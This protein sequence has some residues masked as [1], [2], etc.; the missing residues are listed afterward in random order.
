MREIGSLDDHDQAVRLGDYLLAQ[1]IRNRVETA[2]GRT[3]IWVIDEDRIDQAMQELDRFRAEPNHDRYA[4]A[5]SAARAIRRDQQAKEKRYRKNVVNVRNRWHGQSWRHR[6]VTTLLLAA[7]IV[8][9]LATWFGTNRAE[10]LMPWLTIVPYQFVLTHDGVD[11]RL[12]VALPRTPLEA[13][14]D[15][16]VWRIVTPIFIHFDVFHLL[17]NM[18]WLVVLGTQIELFRGP[19]RMA[20]FTLL[21]AAASNLGQFAWSLHNSDMPS[22]FIGGMSGVDYALFGYVWMQRMFNPRSRFMLS[23]MTILVMI[24]WLFLCMTPLSFVA[25]VAN[26]AHVVG[27]VVGLALG[28]GDAFV[29]Q[30]HASKR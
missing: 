2:S 3:S 26:A 8:V 18:Y 20:I 16:Q 1:G 6:P 19:V 7:S 25:N 30:K 17:F 12:D 11:A 29:R 22:V 15:G 13:F 23:E 9:T 14:M 24:G 5:A 21:S 10:G 28:A 27:L 4:Q